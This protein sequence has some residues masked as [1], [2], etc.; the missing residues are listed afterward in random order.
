MSVDAIRPPKN[1]VPLDQTG[2][3]DFPLISEC[4]LE[5]REHVVFLNAEVFLSLS[6]VIQLASETSYLSIVLL[7]L[8]PCMIS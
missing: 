2:L 8:V 1:F 5:T 3:T 6:Q 7:G 4:Y